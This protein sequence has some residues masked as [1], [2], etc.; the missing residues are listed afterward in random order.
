MALESLNAP[1]RSTPT[2]TTRSLR[3]PNAQPT[4]TRTSQSQGTEAS[5]R[6]DSV[7][8]GALQQNTAVSG[9]LRGSIVNLV[10]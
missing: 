5:E 8:A 9:A 7:P 6:T 10:V 3:T 2:L 4:E 1:V